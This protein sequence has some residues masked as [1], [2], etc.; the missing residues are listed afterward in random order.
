MGTFQINKE[1]IQGGIMIVNSLTYILECDKN[2]SP[3]VS[4]T[5]EFH[6]IS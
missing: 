5:N 2:G 3:I 1:L 4:I 6:R